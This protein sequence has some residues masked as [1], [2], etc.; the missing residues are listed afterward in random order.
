MRDERI[1][2]VSTVVRGEEDS[3]VNLFGQN[4]IYSI[5]KE[6]INNLSEDW[7]LFFNTISLEPLKII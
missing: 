4:L 1:S 3:L 6:K 5:T 2:E 7:H